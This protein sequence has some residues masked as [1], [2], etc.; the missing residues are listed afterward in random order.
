MCPLLLQHYPDAPHLFQPVLPPRGGAEG[1]KKSGIIL[2]PYWHPPPCKKV[3]NAPAT[4]SKPFWAPF[5]AM[6]TYVYNSG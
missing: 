6:F 2:G 1:Q 5:G 3:P 4:M